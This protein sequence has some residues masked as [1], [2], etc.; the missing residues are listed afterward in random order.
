MNQVSR[1]SSKTQNNRWEYVAI[2]SFFKTYLKT[3]LLLG[4]LIP[5]QTKYD[6]QRQHL[7][8]RI[9]W[10]PLSTMSA[11]PNWPDLIY[12]FN[13]KSA[14]ALILTKISKTS[15][16]LHHIFEKLPPVLPLHLPSPLPYGTG[17]APGLRHHHSTPI[18][19]HLLTPGRD[20]SWARDVQTCQLQHSPPAADREGERSLGRC[21]T[22]LLSFWIILTFNFRDVV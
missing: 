9:P 7:G 17:T 1:F 2:S 10:W 4:F 13:N 11:P 15:E 12:K 22:A 5:V 8:L 16:F 19:N 18:S 6:M 3:K 21:E 20:N 14:V